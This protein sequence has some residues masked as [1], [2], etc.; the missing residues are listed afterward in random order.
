MTESFMLK[1]N[2]TVEEIS[3]EIILEWSV[4]YLGFGECFLWAPLTAVEIDVTY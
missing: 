1:L 4:I 2:T 3:S